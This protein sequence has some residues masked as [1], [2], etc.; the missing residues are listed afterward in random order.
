MH[1][2][3]AING[4]DIINTRN[5]VKMAQNG[6]YLTYPKIYCGQLGIGRMLS[7]FDF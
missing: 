4:R 5:M 7:I 1:K 2:K 3:V 6:Q